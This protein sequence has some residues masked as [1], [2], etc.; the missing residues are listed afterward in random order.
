M[1]KRTKKVIEQM[2]SCNNKEKKDREY[3]ENW[4]KNTKS[5][6]VKVNAF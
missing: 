3:E 2:F 1:N 4:K 5:L 6:K